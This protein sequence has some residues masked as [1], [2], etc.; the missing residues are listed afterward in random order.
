MHRKRGEIEKWVRRIM[1]AGE[2]K[3]YI[4]YIKHR[5]EEGEELRAI[6]GEIIDDV[7]RGYIIIGDEMIPFHRVEEIRDVN[8]KLLYSRK[9]DKVE[10]R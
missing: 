5:T 7:R 8:G 9:R 2:K 10:K 1:F 3:K 4:I 6:P